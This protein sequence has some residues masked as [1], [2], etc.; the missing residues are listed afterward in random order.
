MPKQSYLIQLH[1]ETLPEAQ[2]FPCS[3]HEPWTDHECGKI[4]L[5]ECR[6]C[7]LLCSEHS[8]KHIISELKQLNNKHQKWLLE[9]KQLRQ[10]KNK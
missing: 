5:H 8:C 7:G 10:A 3:Y 1:W 4:C 2:K 9:Q 6:A